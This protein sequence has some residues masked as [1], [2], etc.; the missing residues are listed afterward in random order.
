MSTKQAIVSIN[1]PPAAIAVISEVVGALPACKVLISHLGLP[2]RY[3]SVQTH[4]AVAE[5]L[6]PLLAL[7]RS[8]NVFVKFSGLYAIG[9][10][11]DELFGAITQPFVDLAL[12]AFGPERLLWGSDFPPV[13]DHMS[14]ARTLDAEQLASCTP[15]EIARIMGGNLIQLL[16]NPRGSQ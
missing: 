9:D 7:A 1:A 10:P 4:A 14:F 15:A 11:A 13:L 2:G 5:S 6:G 12:E 3:Q 16:D 8:P